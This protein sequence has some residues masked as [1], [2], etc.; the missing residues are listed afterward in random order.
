MV[1]M[2]NRVA[3]LLCAVFF[4]PMANAE[5]EGRRIEE[6]IV[7][8]EKRE[9]TVSD[10]SISI[11]AFGEDMIED[12][13]IQGPDELVNFI[14]ATTRDAYDI[15]IRGVGRNFRA[16]GG[17]PGV[18]TYYNGIYS[19]DFGIASTENGLY[20][21]ARIEVLRGPQGTLYGRNSI[22]GALNY[23][24]N[25]PTQEFEA[26]FR[27]V[28][29][30]FG[31]QEYYGLLSGPIIK[32]KLAY[33]VTGVK[34]DRDG[35]Q[36]GLN[37]SEDI[38]TFDDRNMSAALEWNISDNV[39]AYARW[40]DRSSD[41]IIGMNSVVN[42]GFG[43]ARGVR[44]TTS[45]VFGSPL[46]GVLRGFANTAA[47]NPG[48]GLAN[49]ALDPDLEDL[50]GH[51]ATNNDNNETFDQTGV[52][53]ELA[54]DINETTSLK[55]MFGWQ[56]FEYTFDIDLDYT[57]GTF[58]QPRQTVLEDVETNSHELQLLWQIG[59]KLE[60][61]SGVY[62]FESKRLQ[63][64]AFRDDTR[65]TLP[66]GYGNLAGFAG[67][68]YG[69]PTHVRR[70]DAPVGTSL[71]GP[72]QGDPR[73]ASYEYWNRVK[74]DATAV[75]T[76]GT[77]R[78]ND[79]WALTVGVRWAE[80][81]KTAFEDRV[82]YIE[83]PFLDAALD[84]FCDGPFGFNT[85]CSALGVTPLAF[86]NILTGAAVPTFNPA[87]PIVPTCPLGTTQADCP[88]AP[89][90]LNGVPFSFAD[91][92]AGEDDWGDTSFRVNLD[93]EPNEDTLV[94]FSVTT[95]YRAGGY[96]LGIGDS[97][98]PGN[99][100][101]MEPLTYDQEEVIAY[102]IGYKGTLADGRV[103]LNLSAYQYSYD[104]YQDRVEVTTAFNN[105]SSQDQVVNAEE[106]EN[107]GF[108]FELMWLASDNLTIGANGSY[109]DTEYTSDLFVLEDDNPLIA[110]QRVFNLNGSPLKRIPEW[111][112]TLWANYTWQFEA[113]TLDAGAVYAYTG[114]YYSSGIERDLDLVPDR[115]R[116][117]L[118]LTWR[119]SRDRWTLRAFV[120]NALDEVYARGIGTGGPGTNYRQ[121]AELLY[122][123][124]YGVD[125][126]FRWGPGF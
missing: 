21:V 56:D 31:S 123:R 112:G 102:E 71:I 42:E 72:W 73:G 49:L 48:F 91:R 41:R 70:G 67:A 97:R 90:L 89:L 116:V 6:V 117:D 66:F 126:T 19:E 119:D 32:D 61:T 77:Y 69:Q 76:Q 15:R 55:Y 95:G 58:V 4:I 52:Q 87:N 120:D 92:A 11:T 26:E 54:W 81:E 39:S 59:D 23:I 2:R 75:Y 10:T 74:T 14:P 28:Q 1:A 25:R 103:Q 83:L 62:F 98:G 60:M 93:W 65:F 8:A 124:Y 104:N 37:G 13:G 44:D 68:I 114:E 80:D 7:T 85:D 96:S 46:P 30:S 9:S 100:G 108:E 51:V 18:A 17:D 64:F 63:N 35:S 122:P 53:F 12:F 40:N 34:T 57:N 79:T 43:A 107:R 78:F 86:A 101:G 33:R 24:T 29:G 94:Y 3:V 118:S 84:G 121:T 110:A 20:D 47:P 106:A 27:T 109:T 50:E 16:L 82:A 113:G 45:Y 111:K 5:E 88:A 36:D 38:N 115:R 22:G 99:F 105:I 125:F